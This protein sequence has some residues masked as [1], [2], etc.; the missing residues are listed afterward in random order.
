MRLPPFVFAALAAPCVAATV[1]LGTVAVAELGGRSPWG[2][3]PRNPSEAAAMGHTA[4]LSRFIQRGY[5]PNRAYVVRHETLYMG[6]FRATPLEAA[7]FG[8]QEEV[9]TLLLERGAILDDAG[10][11]R[12]VCLAR[13][14]SA[15]RIVPLIAG[16]A[17]VSCEPGRTSD[18][19]L[20]RTP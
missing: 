1:G 3:T 9:V 17:P 15:E 19:L 11:A 5:D 2:V 12:L 16:P 20:G 14:L 6:D 13:D 10:R 7:M 4:D 18:R 8:R